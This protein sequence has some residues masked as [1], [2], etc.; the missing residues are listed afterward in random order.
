MFESKGDNM[1][2]AKVKGIVESLPTDGQSGTI[3]LRNGES[4]FFKGDVISN[5]F[6]W[7]EVG[8]IAIGKEVKLWATR[9][10]CEADY[11]ATLIESTL[12]PYGEEELEKARIHNPLNRR[13]VKTLVD[14][15]RHEERERL[16]RQAEGL[17]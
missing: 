16:D 14:P 6:T 5:E 7:T 15:E 12:E 11:T 8:P 4:V 2:L 9:P 1:P 17:E 13:I 3:R 10:R